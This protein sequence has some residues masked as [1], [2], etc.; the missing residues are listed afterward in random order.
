MKNK[1]ML[2]ARKCIELK[3]I[4][5]S[6][7]VSCALPSVW[8]LELNNTTNN[9]ISSRGG[10]TTAE[11]EVE[12]REQGDARYRGSHESLI[13]FKSSRYIIYMKI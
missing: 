12:R 4:L 6:K 11:R 10:D 2:S 7:E 1:I 5:Q 8:K 3:V 9:T 13:L